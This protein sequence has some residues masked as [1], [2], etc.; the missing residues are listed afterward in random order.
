LSL[1]ETYQ[2]VLELN[3]GEKQ[4]NT[5]PNPRKRKAPK[6]DEHGKIPW[7]N[8][9]NTNTL[10]DK[11]G[12]VAFCGKTSN[13][14][15]VLDLDDV[16]LYDELKDDTFTVQSGKRGY[17]IYY[18]VESIP[19]S[20]SIIN[21]KGQHI[22]IL[23]QGKVAVLPPSIHPETNKPYTI[24]NDS[25]IKV[26]SKEEERNLFS[27][28]KSMGF[29]E[30]TIQKPISELLDSDH[31]TKEGGNRGLEILRVCDSWKL[32]NPDLDRETLVQACMKYT[33]DHH[34]PPLPESKIQGL[35]DQSLGFVANHKIEPIVVEK[36]DK[37]GKNTVDNVALELINR[38]HFA[39]PRATDEIHLFNGKVYDKSEAES[40]IKEE[41]DKIIAN[42]TTNDRNEVINKIKVKTYV[43]FNDF[44]NEVWN[45][46]I[47]NGILNL[48]TLEIRDHTPTHLSKILIPLDY[49]K[50]Q[51]EIKDKTI[52]ADIEKNLQ[53]TLFY[54]SLKTAF[55]IDDVF[56]KDDFETVLEMISS[57]FVRR[58]VDARQFLNLGNGGNGKSVILDYVESLLGLN[59]VSH[60]SL[61]DIEQH[62]FA[63]AELDG[64]VA[65]IVDDIEKN[66]LKTS[67]KIKRLFDGGTIQ[68]EKKYGK[69]YDIDFGGKFIFS[70]NRFPKTSDQSSAFF[71]RWIL[72][73]WD[74][75][76][77]N[78]D[79]KIK[80][81]KYL[82]RDNQEEK[83]KV[84]S[85]LI[86]LS[87]KLYNDQEFSHAKQWEEVKSFWLSNADPIEA[88]VNNWT[89]YAEEDTPKIVMY[90]AY[91]KKMLDIGETPVTIG[92]FGK[93]FAEYYDEGRDSTGKTR[94]WHNVAVKEPKQTRLEERTP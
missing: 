38:Y 94:V 21:D 5:H 77:K 37:T 18:R 9:P 89:Q 41:T 51:Y 63:N 57:C 32:N 11:D 87:R 66:E 86:H 93:E 65:N 19:K 82:L 84:F 42:S 59:N 47:N 60:V 88:F 69:P 70:C 24:V 54:K 31:K 40:I 75:D 36:K 16:A 78:S 20:N 35:V 44:D 72:I 26:L 73:K 3:I 61:Q 43:D 46:T 22:D 53:D 76:F 74:K 25:K 39:T 68:V 92:T 30:P 67:S 4:P 45:I 7:H 58:Q 83:N 64:K 71:R 56:R 50:P 15:L 34:E 52:F 55:T 80:G 23:G 91:K 2:N 8:I 10:D 79:E 27:K 62:Q 6:F 14:L 81:L 49:I 17:H 1:I 13:N 48:E 12:L 33:H 28:L 85:A 29:N 90:Q